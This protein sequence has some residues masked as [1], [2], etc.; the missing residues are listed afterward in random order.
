M[1]VNAQYEEVP[2]WRDPY[3]GCKPIERFPVS[4]L[5]VPH[6]NGGGYHLDSFERR[7][8]NTELRIENTVRRNH[9]SMNRALR[10]IQRSK[11]SIEMINY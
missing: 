8:V 1:R 11:S 10:N 9:Q 6:C 2:D 5:N 4:D 3:L 7:V